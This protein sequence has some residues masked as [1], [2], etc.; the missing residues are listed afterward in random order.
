MSDRLLAS[1]AVTAVL[2]LTAVSLS[3]QTPPAMNA[4]SGW[5]AI[6]LC[7]VRSNE[8]ARHA[9]IDDVLRQAGLLTPQA[10]AGERRRQFGLEG[11]AAAAPVEPPAPPV[12][13]PP[14]AAPKIAAPPDAPLP[15]K[16]EAA[17][18]DRLE[19][20][21]ATAITGLD[22][23]A[24]LTTTDGAVWQ[25]T[26]SDTIQRLPRARDRFTVRKA[27]LGSYLCTLPSKITFRC[28]RTR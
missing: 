4:E 23:K 1:A 18:G 14:I 27:S 12:A 9:C 11:G 5:S 25:Q 15:P 3:A 20:E 26:D 19:L 28:R 16:P 7:A 6:G 21:I 17:S 8:R 10:E 22:D 13:A 24:V 2:T